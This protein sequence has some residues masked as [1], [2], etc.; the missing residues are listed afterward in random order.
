MNA[1]NTI[2]KLILCYQA[3]GTEILDKNY[4]SRFKNRDTEFY[5]FGNGIMGYSNSSK[6]NREREI[7]K[8]FTINLQLGQKDIG[9]L[10]ITNANSEFFYFKYHKS[11]FYEG[12]FKIQ[13]VKNLIDNLF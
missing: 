6:P 4:L 7:T 9:T 2:D 11:I 12:I 1:K 10:F 13:D 5:D 3:T 8:S